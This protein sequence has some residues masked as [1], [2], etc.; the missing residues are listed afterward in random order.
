MFYAS[1]DIPYK[2]V[3]SYVNQELHDG[4]KRKFIQLKQ[5][6]IFE[7]PN[8]LPREICMQIEKRHLEMLLNSLNQI[9]S[10]D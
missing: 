7:D 4:S 8:E 1:N 10:E 2:F 3:V 6:F 9:A 5:E